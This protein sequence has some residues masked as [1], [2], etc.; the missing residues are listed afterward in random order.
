MAYLHEAAINNAT[1]NLYKLGHKHPK[2]DTSFEDGAVGFVGSAINAE[3]AKAAQATL[4]KKVQNAKYAP[5]PE[6]KF[7]ESPSAFTQAMERG[8]KDRADIAS[9][10]QMGPMQRAVTSQDMAQA[11]IS[12]QKLNDAAQNTRIDGQFAPS[13]FQRT[14]QEA[15]LNGQDRLRA[16]AMLGAGLQMGLGGSMY[17]P[18]EQWGY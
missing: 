7:E 15:P 8:M 2:D 17:S 5:G 10:A 12:Q 6:M 4:A 16:R 14:V 9:V 1:K 3:R 18:D 11:A 13:G